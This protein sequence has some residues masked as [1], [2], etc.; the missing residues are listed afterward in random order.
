MTWSELDA[1]LR[2]HDRFLLSSHV[3]PDGDCIGSQLA[4]AWYLES[5]GKQVTVYNCDTVP[6]KFALLRGSERITRERPDGPFDVLIVL[7]SSN[8]TRLG[9]EGCEQSAP[10]IVNIDHHH[11]NTSF[12][13]YN[14][15]EPASA[16][17]QILY[18][19][20][21]EGGVRYPPFVAEALYAAIMTDTGGFRFSNT[22]AEVLH[23]CA[24]LA[25]RGADPALIYEKVY[26]SNTLNGMRLHASIW[27]TLAF[28]LDGRV[29]TMELPLGLID[30]LGATYG[31]S[32]GMAD[33]TLMAADVLVGVFIKHTDT[34]THFS[35]RSKNHIDV[36]RMARRIAGGG[37]HT[38]AAGC[39]IERPINEAFPEML[40]I[41]RE[42]L[43]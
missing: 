14:L 21:E 39:T 34:L 38:N 9:W 31:D 17:G 7:D 30:E 36:G 29:C 16:T 5:I 37:G 12:G 23:I 8:P 24:D 41:I 40:R 42:E 27:N 4:V 19:L 25:D 26:A 32:E 6:Y 18:R 10:V 1:I 22:T 2:N 20:F 28:H 43:G 15:V 33:L 13:T 11:D 3:N 35:L